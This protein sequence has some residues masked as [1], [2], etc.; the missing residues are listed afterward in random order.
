MPAY[1]PPLG[2]LRELD[3]PIWARRQIESL[4]SENAKLKKRLEAATALV[5]NHFDT[6]R[7]VM[8]SSAARKIRGHKS[9]GGW[10]PGV[11]RNAFIEQVAREVE[12]GW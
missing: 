6:L 11:N 9:V 4:Q 2:P 8:L 12:E 10:P 5:N 1:K 3:L 7:D